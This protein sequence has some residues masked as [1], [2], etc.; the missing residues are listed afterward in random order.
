[1]GQDGQGVF[2]QQ[3]QKEWLGLGRQDMFSQNWKVNTELFRYYRIYEP[4]RKYG[5]YYSKQY[6]RSLP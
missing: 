2:W 4:Y 3:K 6:T 1:L 5:Q